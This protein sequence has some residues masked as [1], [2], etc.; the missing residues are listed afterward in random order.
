VRQSPRLISFFARLWPLGV[1]LGAC[2]PTRAETE[3]PKGLRGCRCEND[4]CKLSSLVC[5]EDECVD[6]SGLAGAPGGCAGSAGQAS[7]GSGGTFS[8]GAGGEPSCSVPECTGG[9]CADLEDYCAWAVPRTVEDCRQRYSDCEACVSDFR[10]RAEAEPAA[11]CD[12][13]FYCYRGCVVA[14]QDLGDDNVRKCISSSCG[15]DAGATVC[16]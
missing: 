12:E 5:V 9:Y 1:V 13:L 15:G 10:T 4:G 11:Y 2:L 16:D 7:G 3:C 14:N 6:K 8:V